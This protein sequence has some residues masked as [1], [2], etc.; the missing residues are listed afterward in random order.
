M[1]IVHETPELYDRIVKPYIAAFPPSRTKWYAMIASHASPI[2]ATNCLSTCRVENI[3]NGTSEA[4]KVLFRDA[5][6][7]SG[8]LILPDMKWDLA[9]LSSLYLV[10]IA[11]NREIRSLRDLTKAHIPML[12]S[13]RREG[14]R[15]VQERWGLGAGSLRMFIHYQPSYCAL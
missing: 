2:H 5:S 9:T 11:F 3:L 8:Y 7:E 4:E 14:A 15:V 6:P 1:A 13:I 10:A 12:T